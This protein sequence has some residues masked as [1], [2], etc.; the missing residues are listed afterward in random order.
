VQK[1][2]KKR[3]RRTD[4][5]SEAD[6]PVTQV[7]GSN[8]NVFFNRLSMPDGFVWQALFFRCA[9]LNDKF[10]WGKKKSE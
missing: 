7:C 6:Q 2:E 8:N 4:L 10:F 5:E 1:E 3:G 9:K